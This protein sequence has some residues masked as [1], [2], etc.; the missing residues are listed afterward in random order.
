MLPVRDG[1]KFE[2]RCHLCAWTYHKWT[3]A[4]ARELLMDHLDTTHINPSDLAAWW[5]HFC[6]TNK[7]KR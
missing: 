6:D 2:A 1:G 4:E 3:E 7:G 5:E